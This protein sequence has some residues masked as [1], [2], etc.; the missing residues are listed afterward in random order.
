MRINLFYLGACLILIACQH[1]GKNAVGSNIS[2]AEYYNFGD[3]GLQ[4]LV[5]G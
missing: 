3:T 4:T 5:S 2:V 1:T